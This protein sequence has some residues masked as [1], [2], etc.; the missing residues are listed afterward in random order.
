MF[1]K[2]TLFSILLASS[3]FAAAQQKY[4]T[5]TGY[6]RF[7]S[8]ASLEDIEAKNRSVTAVLDSKSGSLQFSV[9]MKSFEFEK[10][11]MQQHFNEDYVQSDKYPKAVFKGTITNNSS[12][13][14]SKPGTYKAI[15]TGK[16]TMHGV[17]RTVS[18]PGTVTVDA[19]GIKTASTFNIKLSDYGIT[20]PSPVKSKISNTIRIDVDARMDP[21]K[22]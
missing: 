3:L 2:T 7:F 16:L 9:L 21:L 8:S 11:L 20:I 1:R 10:S 4:Y 13:N 5:K 18:A 19:K 12:V 15:V 22:S 14:Y 6:I 17:T